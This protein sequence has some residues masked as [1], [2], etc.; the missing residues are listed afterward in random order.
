MSPWKKINIGFLLVLA[1]LASIHL[2]WVDV[3]MVYFVAIVLIYTGI[4]VYGSFVLSAQVYLPVLWRGTSPG[5]EIAVTFDDGPIRGKTER[6]LD[7]LEQ[8]QVKAAFFCIGNR[9]RGNE[10]IL[11]RIE[12][13][14]HIIGNHTFHH[15]P[16][17][18]FLS[19]KRIA[20]ELN[21]TDAE[22]ARV[23]AHRPMFFRPP[24]G[25]SNPMVG[26]AA[27]LGNY[28]TVGWSMRSFDTI[29]ADPAK[30]LK[31][32]LRA[33]APGDIVLLHDYCESTITMLPA[34]LE[35]LKNDNFQ[36]VRLDA[37]LKESPYR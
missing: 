7:I 6:I 18:G 36:V 30:L 23:I 37:L 19:S 21:A 12:R 28:K 31:R 5:R 10:D 13:D 1:M 34:L 8:Y 29:I 15:Q 11:S 16:Q 24:F 3:S 33:R 4:C 2:A 35:R 32:I 17:F 22:V 14:G 9:I 20:D 26:R 25:V 27:T